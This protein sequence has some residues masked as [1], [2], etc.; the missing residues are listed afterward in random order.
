MP[1]KSA[2][3][4]TAELP[5]LT[6]IGSTEWLDDDDQPRDSEPDFTLDELEWME[7]YE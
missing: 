6:G 2:S 5:T 7:T 1:D 4:A 3:T